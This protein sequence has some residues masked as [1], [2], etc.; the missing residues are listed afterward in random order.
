[1]IPAMEPTSERRLE[2]GDWVVARGPMSGA[3]GLGKLSGGEYDSEDGALVR[4]RV[5]LPSG[6]RWIDA[7]ELLRIGPADEV[8]LAE[9]ALLRDLVPEPRATRV[10][11]L[12]ARARGAR[13]FVRTPGLLDAVWAALDDPLGAPGLVEWFEGKHC[14]PRPATR[15]QEGSSF[16]SAPDP[17]WTAR[18]APS[19]VATGSPPPPDPQPGASDPV[20]PTTPAD[21]GPAAPPGAESRLALALV[22]AV[23][24][25]LMGAIVAVLLPPSQPFPR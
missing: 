23:L 12:L 8:A 14:G 16:W 24:I 21:A 5:E 19:T 3:H 22:A 15:A 7:G 2:A 4:A 18:E 6:V 1:M 10:R 9:E 11:E 25:V 20:E 13:A 17:T